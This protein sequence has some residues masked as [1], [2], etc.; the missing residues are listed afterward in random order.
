MYLRK[1]A[2][3]ADYTVRTCT[4]KGRCSCLLVSGFESGVAQGL[5]AGWCTAAGKRN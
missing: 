3:H 2:Q 4:G 5:C 1:P